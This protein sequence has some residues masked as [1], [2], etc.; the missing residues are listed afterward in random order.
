MAKNKTREKKDR[1]VSS[2]P[3]LSTLG[4]NLKS[5]NPKVAEHFEA[6]KGIELSVPRL[7]Q[8][9]EDLLPY[10]WQDQSYCSTYAEKS[11]KRSCTDRKN[12]QC[13]NGVAQCSE[14]GHGL[15]SA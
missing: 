3:A 5:S 4:E 10:P 8:V 14:P 7:V 12:Q 6:I 1:S 11:K 13:S 2:G 15:A 9:V